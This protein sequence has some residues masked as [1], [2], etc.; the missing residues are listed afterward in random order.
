VSD[1]RTQVAGSL[2]TLIGA[3]VLDYLTSKSITVAVLAIVIGAHLYFG[4]RAEIARKRRAE[5]EE[6][7]RRMRE[8]GIDPDVDG[9]AG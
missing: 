4:A 6:S 7:R 3:G 8:A 5:I 9:D 2:L 1:Q